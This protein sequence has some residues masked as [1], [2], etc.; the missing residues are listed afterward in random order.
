MDDQL[1][2]DFLKSKMDTLLQQPQTRSVNKIT[3]YSKTWRTPAG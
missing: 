2:Y 3:S 1:F